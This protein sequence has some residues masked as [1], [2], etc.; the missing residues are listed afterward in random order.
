LLAGR[1]VIGGVAVPG[2]RTGL[3]FGG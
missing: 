1:L 3:I 2:S